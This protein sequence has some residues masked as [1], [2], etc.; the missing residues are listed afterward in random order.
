MDMGRIRCGET[1]LF[2][3]LILALATGCGLNKSAEEVDGAEVIL[4]STATPETDET[5]GVVSDSDDEEAWQETSGGLI[6]GTEKEFS[7][8]ERL[9]LPLA[10][11]TVV[12]LVMVCLLYWQQRNR[13]RNSTQD[14]ARKK[15]GGAFC[16]AALRPDYQIGNLHNIGKREEQQDSFC[17]SDIR[18]ELALEQ[19]GL[20]AVVADGM[21][22][23]ED[24]AA[25]SQL[26][27]DTFLRC[28]RQK[29]VPD[30]DTFLYTATEAS[31]RAVQ[32]YM[33]QTG[34]NGGSTLIAVL[35][36]GDRMHYISV[37]DSH[38]YLLRRGQLS[39]INREH[40]LGA[41]LLEQAARGEVDPDEPYVN[42]QRNAL[43]AY[44]GIGSL[45]RVDRSETPI[46]LQPG[47]KIMLCSDGVF[48][49]LGDDALCE[50]LDGDV[51]KATLRLEAAVL[52]QNLS[53]Q[54]NFTAI[55]V[56]WKE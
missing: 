30:P 19:K 12:L 17:L 7:I 42:P 53:N 28:Y 41:D 21:G 24:G 5:S 43:T 56:E 44:I 2:I 35:L 50:A 54:D 25:I 40:T 36:R 22:G 52:E 55:L 16:G 20:L 23:M 26:V 32:E 27:T 51:A 37:G 48:N 13:T 15:D 39:Q 46:P 31:E 9:F 29:S 34:S 14:F 18:D 6:G 45:N 33:K 1:L 10:A 8:R 38:I 49:A 47:D 4:N 3:V 11:T